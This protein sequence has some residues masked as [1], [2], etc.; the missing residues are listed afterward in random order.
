[1]DGKIRHRPKTFMRVQD[2]IMLFSSSNLSNN[3]EVGTCP[4]TQTLFGLQLIS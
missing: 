3:G 2:S 4:A 1:M